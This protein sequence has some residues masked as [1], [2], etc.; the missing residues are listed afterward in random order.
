[1]NPPRT[2]R[3][4]RRAVIPM[5][6]ALL[7]AFSLTHGGSDW[8]EQLRQWAQ[9]AT[10]AAHSRESV[11]LRPGPIGT[12]ITVTP[13]RPQGN[14]SSVSTVALPLTLV[15]T[16]PGRNSREGFAQ[17]GVDSTSPQTYSAG[18]LLANGARLTEI[19][20]RYVVLERDGHSAQL[21]VRGASQERAG[22]RAALLTVGGNQRPTPAL[23][24]TEDRLFSY[25]RLS[26]VFVG[27][28]LHGYALYPNRDPGP[29]SRLG[30]EPGDLV[31]EIN[32]A[33]TSNPREALVALHSLA[34]GASVAVVIERQGIAH[35]ISLDGAILTHASVAADDPTIPKPSYTDLK[36][37]FRADSSL[38]TRK[39]G[40]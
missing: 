31:T 39:P 15:R 28:Q 24:K 20:S 23:A 25:L 35:P 30:L 26:P 2:T 1:V 34:D 21:Y 32:G 22:V 3:M 27:N 38:A 6:V 18:A 29:F 9:P 33:P 37:A 14:D 4:L 12:P 11:K 36:R 40:P 10:H 13:M 7:V 19:Y 16:Q 8:F 17:I 5:I